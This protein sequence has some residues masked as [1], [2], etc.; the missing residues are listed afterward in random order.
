GA[1]VWDG[2][3]ACST[4][5]ADPRCARRST[6]DPRWLGGRLILVERGRQAGEVADHLGVIGTIEAVE[7]VSRGVERSLLE[8]DVLTGSDLDDAVVELVADERVAIG[9]ADCAR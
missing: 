4:S 2:S 8:H 3:R 5:P 9:Q 7:A 1:H 6:R